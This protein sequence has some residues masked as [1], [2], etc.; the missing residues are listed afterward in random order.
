MN[1]PVFS[2]DGHAVSSQE[3]PTHIVVA[4]QTID[5]WM[6]KNGYKRWQLLNICDRRFAYDMELVNKNIEQVI[7]SLKNANHRT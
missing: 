3:I 6:T 1:V 4:A 5:N 7:K 2:L